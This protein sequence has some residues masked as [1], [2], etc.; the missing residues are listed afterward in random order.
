MSIGHG[1]SW[2]RNRGNDWVTK[3]VAQTPRQGG[4][5]FLFV[6][7]KQPDGEGFVTK[8]Y[9]QKRKKTGESIVAKFNKTV[10]IFY[11]YKHLNWKRSL[12]RKITLM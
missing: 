6:I 10:R 9:E 5:G 12:I 11:L 2:G 3:V 8:L 1:R 4:E 7:Q